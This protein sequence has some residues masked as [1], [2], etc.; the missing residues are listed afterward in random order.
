MRCGITPAAVCP[1]P[2]AR[3]KPSLW[4]RDGALGLWFG[5]GV[6]S[7]QGAALGG[8]AAALVGLGVSAGVGGGG[9]VESN[10][11]PSLPKGCW[12]CPGGG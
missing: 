6:A 3:R 5:I 11:L 2:A 4:S 12:T 9:H 7:G 1:S 8:V 10:S